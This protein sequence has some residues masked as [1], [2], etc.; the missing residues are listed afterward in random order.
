[1]AAMSID[2]RIYIFTKFYR[3]LI[4]KQ[5]YDGEICLKFSEVVPIS[6]NL[7]KPDPTL[8]KSSDSVK[9]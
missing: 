9:M 3:G 2:F 1:M 4:E 8:N 6:G 5:L 7:L